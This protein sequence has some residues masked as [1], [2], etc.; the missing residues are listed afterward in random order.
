M[1][2]D[3][4]NQ[5]WNSELYDDHHGFVSAYGN[6]LI[7]L[8]EPK[9]NEQILDLGCGTGDLA[10]KIYQSGATVDGVDA[11]MD[12]ILKAKEKYPNLTFQVM[13][14]TNLDFEEKFDA[15]F[16]NAVLHWVKNAEG[17]IASC[18]NVL[19]EGGRYVVEFG[20]KDNCH[21]ITSTIIDVVK[22]LNPTYK[23]GEFPWYF[24]TIGQYSAILEHHGFEVSY[25]RHYDRPTPL[26]QGEIGLR[27]WMKMFTS[28]LFDQ[29]DAKQLGQVFDEVEKRLRDQLYKDGTWYADYKRIRIVA[30]KKQSR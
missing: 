8:L 17:V 6:S 29:L 22:E 20:G 18:Y 19:K 1:T 10:F 28:K 3:S 13:D 14:A 12:M 30:I 24:P 4:T 11:S 27:N 2:K 5:K 7:D 23:M 25:A 21:L 26:D 9:K 15:V 16:S